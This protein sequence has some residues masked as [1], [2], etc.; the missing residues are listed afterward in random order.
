[1]VEK[2]RVN[3]I[4]IVPSAV[5]SVITALNAKEFLIDGVYTPVEVKKQQLQQQGGSAAAA[6]ARNNQV[7]QRPASATGRSQA[8]KIV[9]DPAKLSE[10]D[11]QRVVAVFVTGQ[12]WQF[13]GWKYSSPVE[14]FQHV[15]GLHLTIDD[16]VLDPTILTWNCKVLKVRGCLMCLI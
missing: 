14:L 5:T 12:Q 4:I 13:K 11:W 2:A 16:R 7:I 9:D 1:M 8:Y 15:L 10:E 3:P 6:A